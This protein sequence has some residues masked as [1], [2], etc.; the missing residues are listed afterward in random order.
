MSAV[1]L[2]PSM[3]SAMPEYV[4]G[5]MAFHNPPSRLSDWLQAIWFNNPF[6]ENF[7]LETWRIHTKVNNRTQKLCL[8]LSLHNIPCT[9]SVLLE[10]ILSCCNFHW[11]GQR[12]DECSARDVP[13]L[14]A[15]LLCACVSGR[16]RGFSLL[17]SFLTGSGARPDSHA[18]GTGG[19]F[20]GG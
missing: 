3:S 15:R 7:N 4:A 6:R 11:Y 16:I 10:A 2:C 14:E 8:F 17:H 13:E 1:A 9:E 12:F 19:D 5:R 20:P 18:V